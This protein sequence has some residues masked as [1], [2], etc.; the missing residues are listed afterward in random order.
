MYTSNGLEKIILA[1]DGSKYAEAADDA[2][3]ALA[4][5]SRAEVRV[6]HVWN[7]DIRQRHCAWDVEVRSEARHLLDATVGRLTKA[8]IHA[9]GAILR[10]DSDHVAAAVVA[11]AKT[12]NA[13][14]V[15]IGSRG[16]S[17]WQSM[18]DQTV[19]H[20]LLSAADCPLLM[21]RGRTLTTGQAQRVLLAVSGGDDIGRAARA[22]IAVASA[23]DCLVVVVHAGQLLEVAY[24]APRS[25]TEDETRAPIAKAITLIEEA[26]IAARGIATQPGRVAD[27]IARIANTWDVDLIV[28]GSSR[29][30]DLGSM[31]LGSVSHELLHASGR[32]VLTAG[33]ALS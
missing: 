21:V 5:G 11:S 13:D 22:A 3:I 25:E 30:G 20:Q 15:V 16:L 12:F 2:T 27:V 18:L 31:V 33:L 4:R 32:P 26:G 7:L 1:T 8:G 14:L 19:S 6:V 10:A 9:E 29:M 28:T 24:G 17:D 23:P